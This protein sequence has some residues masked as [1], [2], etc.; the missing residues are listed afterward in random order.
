[1][2]T[3]LSTLRQNVAIGFVGGSDFAKQQEQLGTSEVPVTSPLT[4]ASRRTVLQPINLA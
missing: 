2:L 3:L 1:M 4:F